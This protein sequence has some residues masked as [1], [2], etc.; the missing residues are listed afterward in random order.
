MNQ[1]RSNG[2]NEGDSSA[3]ALCNRNASDMNLPDGFDHKG[4]APKKEWTERDLNPRPPEFLALA[5]CLQVRHSYQ[6]E[7]SAQ[8]RTE[9]MN[10]YVKLNF[11]DYPF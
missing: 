6:T 8:T 2:E 5:Y 9:S 3:H 10:A 11:F 1:E 4:S 7:L